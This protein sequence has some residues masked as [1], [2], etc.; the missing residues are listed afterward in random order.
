MKEKHKWMLSVIITILIIG[1]IY[2]LFTYEQG[3][4]WFYIII[5][6][7]LGIILVGALIASIKEFIDSF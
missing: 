6:A 2:F 1:G 3:L 7:V 4:V 5:T